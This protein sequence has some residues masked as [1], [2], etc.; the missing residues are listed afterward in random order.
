[1]S[2]KKFWFL[3]CLIL[4]LLSPKISLSKEI[5]GISVDNF[6]N[7]REERVLGFEVKIKSGS[8][9]SLPKVL[10]MWDIKIRNYLNDEPYWN[11]HIKASAT[12]GA[13]APYLD[14]FHDFL[15]I[16]KDAGE[17]ADDLDIQVT[18]ITTTDF[19][20]QKVRVFQMKDL[21]LKS[22]RLYPCLT[23]ENGKQ[24]RR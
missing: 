2:K 24:L 4:V 9:V 17:W 3:L 14:F 6:Q 11:T 1:M 5:L 15:F 13:A 12:V 10:A 22:I 8:I 21:V 7:N 16:E 18:I 19:E 23:E 20:S